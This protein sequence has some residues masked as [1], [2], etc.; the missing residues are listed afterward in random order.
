VGAQSVL[1][2]SDALCMNLVGQNN[3]PE[4]RLASLQTLIMEQGNTAWASGRRR[5]WAGVRATA[6]GAAHN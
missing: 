6:R 3:E 2:V 4:V 1:K 5:K